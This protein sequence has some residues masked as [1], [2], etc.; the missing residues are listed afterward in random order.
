MLTFSQKKSYSDL[1]SD[2]WQL[3]HPP[4]VVN[5]CHPVAPQL[6][7]LCFCLFYSTKMLGRTK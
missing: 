4:P 3:G 6:V 7:S 5:L 1:S 2:S